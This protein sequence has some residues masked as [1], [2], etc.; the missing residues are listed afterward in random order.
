MKFLILL[1]F[2]SS[3]LAA[4]TVTGT[5]ERW[6]KVTLTF[7]GPNVSETATPNPFLDYRLQVDFTHT[8]SGKTYRIPGYFAACGNAAENGCTSG[9]QWRVHFAPDRPGA[10]TRSAPFT[11]GADVAVAG[12]GTPVAH[13]NGTTG[14]LTIQESTKTGKDFRNKDLGRLQ[15]VGEHYLRHM[16]TTPDQPNGPWFFK[17]GPDAPE[18]TLAYDDFDGTPNL[19]SAGSY[20]KSWAPHQQDYWASDASSYTWDNGKGTEL[21]GVLRYLSDSVQD[22]AFNYLP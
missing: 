18:N 10:W 16:G 15:Y 21:L 8:N 22:K 12:G 11:Q 6:H 4:Q 19:R 2:F 20:R 9:D 14:T 7:N 13:I 17:A 5:L 1:L 3:G